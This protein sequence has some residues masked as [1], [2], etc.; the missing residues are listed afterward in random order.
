MSR[1]SNLINIYKISK[2]PFITM[3][4]TFISIDF[5]NENIIDNIGKIQHQLGE[6]DAKLKMVNPKILHLTLEFLGEIT[7]EQIQVVSKILDEI[8]FPK[9]RLEIKQPG[10][11]PNEKYIRVIFCEM[12]GELEVLQNIQK[13]LRFKLKESGFKVDSRGFKPH[14]T[15]ARVKSIKNKSE[16]IKVINNLSKFS[17]GEE[18]IDSINLKKSELYPTGP[19]YTSLHEVKAQ[20]R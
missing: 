13:E 8:K 17:C 1:N 15:I 14:L 19:I 16:L 5:N 7:E 11:L 2:K 3:V 20:K 10:L 18:E 6:I 12:D 4:R 9:F